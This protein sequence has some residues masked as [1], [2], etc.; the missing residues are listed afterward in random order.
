MFQYS[1]LGFYMQP[2]LF[3]SILF[4]FGACIGSFLNV[5][6]YRLPI[7]LKHSWRNQCLE[8]LNDECQLTPTPTSLT[9]A[10]PRS[11]CPHCR[12]MIP[13]WFNLPLVG[14][15]VLRGRCYACQHPISW[16]YP[17]IELITACLFA[18]AGALLPSVS[19]SLLSLILISGLIA[20]IMIDWDTFLLPDEL[21]LP[22]LW[23][24]LLANLDGGFSA[25]LKL[26]VLG[27]AAGYVSLWSLY[28]LFKLITGK[29]GMGYGDFKLLAALGA[30]FGLQSLVSILLISS[31]LGIIYALT[32]RICGLLARGKP[33]PFGPFLGTAGLFVLFVP[34]PLAL[35]G[36]A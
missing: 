19:A 26:A 30:W 34:Q 28:W 18:V 12:Q 25:S 8:L 31:V 14:F 33:I 24:G 23:C 20:L 10:K 2:Q 5:V 21:T 7:M 22:L 35:L 4:V 3:C 9:L 27:A 17:L 36:L 11:H 13:M 32:L 1:F 15:L 16:R 29:E 6:I